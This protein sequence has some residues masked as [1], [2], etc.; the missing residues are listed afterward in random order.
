MDNNQEIITLLQEQNRTL[1][2]LL[3]FHQRKEKDEMRD[4]ILGMIFHA[5]PYII[6]VV[7][8]YIA[9]TTLK[10]YL[11]AVNNEIA[12]LHEKYNS[13][14]TSMQ[15]MVDKITGI[16]NAIVEGVKGIKLF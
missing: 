5:I 13:I 15:S 7:L 2:Q 12:A 3:E 8:L 6:I 10:G 1:H 14:A 11:D 9:Y 4:K 16:P